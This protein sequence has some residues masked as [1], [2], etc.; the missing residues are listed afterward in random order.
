MTDYSHVIDVPFI[1]NPF[2]F[3]GEIG[4]VAEFTWNCAC[5]LNIEG[6]VECGG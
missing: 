5:G 2:V 3:V 4:R 1:A 6:Y